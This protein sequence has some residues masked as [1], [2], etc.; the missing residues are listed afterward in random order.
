M[1]RSQ[2]GNSSIGTIANALCQVVRGVR[3]SQLLPAAHPLGNVA[4]HLIQR[5]ADLVARV[6]VPHGGRLVLLGL[7]VDG[8]AERRARLVH[9]GVALADGLLL[10]ELRGPHAALEVTVQL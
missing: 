6:P 10:V 1:S 4:V 3:R 9:A 2:S 8:D 5:D 7:A